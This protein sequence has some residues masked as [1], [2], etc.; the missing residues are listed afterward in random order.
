M[1]AKGFAVEPHIALV[2]DALEHQPDLLALH[3]RRNLECFEVP[4]FV[5]HHP[6][7]TLTIPADVR[8]IDSP[9]P[10][11]V[12]VDVT[13]HERRPAVRMYLVK[14]LLH[15][16]AGQNSFHLPRARQIEDHLVVHRFVGPCAAAREKKGQ[17][18]RQAMSDCGVAIVVHLS[19]L[20][21]NEWRNWLLSDRA[22]D[23]RVNRTAF[24][25]RQAG[26]AFIHPTTARCLA[27]FPRPP[28][29]TS[30]GSS[31]GNERIVYN[32]QAEALRKVRA[33]R[34]RRCISWMACSRSGNS[35]PKT[36]LLHGAARIRDTMTRN[37]TC[38]LNSTLE[39]KGARTDGFSDRTG[40]LSAARYNRA[41][42][43]GCFPLQ[44]H[45]LANGGQG[46]GS[47]SLSGS[48]D[49]TE[50]T[51]LTSVTVFARLSRSTHAIRLLRQRPF[52]LPAV[53]SYCVVIGICIE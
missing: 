53:P 17:G 9:N 52:R 2:I 43:S 40:R 21:S 37:R 39:L 18:D 38:R 32:M 35:T 8:I 42:R 4:P 41:A 45:G 15:T 26:M 1:I 36:N 13:G 29:S 49:V 25:S 12:G 47:H 46:H 10:P 31:H 19:H 6:L 34:A 48:G 23:D 22:A 51:V 27:A 3:L 28:Q 50:S 11:Q 44:H 30:T 24:T 14:Q 5:V 16:F 20:A 33:V 7:G